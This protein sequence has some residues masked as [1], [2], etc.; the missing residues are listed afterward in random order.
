MPGQRIYNYGLW[1]ADTTEELRKATVTEDVA[2][3]FTM[4]ALHLIEDGKYEEQL[5]LK[6]WLGWVWKHWIWK[7]GGLKRTIAERNT[8][9]GF[10]PWEPKKDDGRA[11]EG[12]VLDLPKCQMAPAINAVSAL[13][14]C[15][16]MSTQ[17]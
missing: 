8:S 5:K 2:V 3:K 17:K 4:H 11:D 14:F 13:S 1:R 15:R 12:R 9:C 10:Q 6:G 7:A 16:M